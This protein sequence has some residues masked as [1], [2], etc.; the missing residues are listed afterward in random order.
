MLLTHDSGDAADCTVTITVD[1]NGTVDTTQVAVKKGTEFSSDGNKLYIGKKTVTATADKGS[2]FKGWNPDK[3][4]VNG[5]MKIAATFVQ[6]I[7]YTVTITAG[8]GGTVS[9]TSVTV[10]SG[11]T[12]NSNGDKLSIGTDTVIATPNQGYSF[13]NW[14]PASGTVMS[15]MT[16]AASFSSGSNTFTFYFTDNF[17]NDEFEPEGAVYATD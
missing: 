14:T 10:N 17:D 4:K 8:T 6:E 3:G 5:D 1:G 11:T 16:I 13:S 9:K 2:I 7:N 15:D 12:F